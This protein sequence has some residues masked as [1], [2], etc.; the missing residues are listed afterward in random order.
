M[1]VNADPETPTVAID[2]DPDENNF[3]KSLIKAGQSLVTKEFP[4]ADGTLPPKRVGAIVLEHPYMCQL[5][6]IL[7]RECEKAVGGDVGIVISDLFGLGRW[8]HEYVI[9][10]SF[11]ALY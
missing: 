2:F 1:S 3:R 11:V 10:F 7:Q 9:L 4:Q 5:G 6:D 8:L